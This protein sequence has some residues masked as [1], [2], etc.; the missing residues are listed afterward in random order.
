[1]T[2]Q[3][4]YDLVLERCVLANGCLLWTGPTYGVKEKYGRINVIG[5][6]FYTH[7]IAYEAAHGP[8][9]KGMT[10]DHRCQVKMCCNVD[11]LRLATKSQNQM[12]RRGASSHSKTGIRGVYPAPKGYRLPWIY[13]VVVEGKFHRGYAATLEEASET[14]AKLREEVAPAGFVGG[15]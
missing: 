3:E 13:K 10:V 12:Y 1:M 7:R 2:P 14:V 9:P 4:I 8:I 11:H 6:A 5:K 15:R